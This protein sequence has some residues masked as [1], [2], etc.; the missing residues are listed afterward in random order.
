[1]AARG[2]VM[3]PSAGLHGRWI[4]W[5]TDLDVGVCDTDGN[6]LPMP[7]SFDSFDETGHLTAFPVNASS[8]TAASYRDEV[9][10]NGPCVLMHEAFLTQGFSELASEWWHFADEDTEAVVQSIVGYQ[11]LDFIADVGNG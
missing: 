4:C 8:I 1:M 11:G 9:S 10:A 5:G 2:V 3:G 6:P 7:S